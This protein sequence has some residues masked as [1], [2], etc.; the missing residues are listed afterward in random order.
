V[1]TRWYGLS[2]GTP[3][4]IGFSVKQIRTAGTS[5]STIQAFES[6][7][8]KDSVIRIE[9]VSDTIY[10][11]K[12]GVVFRSNAASSTA[13]LKG[14]A[15]HRIGLPHAVTSNDSSSISEHT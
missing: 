8:A 2:S 6:G 14:H 4:T 15:I 1:S 5:V 10:Y 9:R 7:T 3:S 12:N 11:K 13:A